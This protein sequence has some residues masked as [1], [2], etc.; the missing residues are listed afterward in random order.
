MPVTAWKRNG[1]PL[2][3]SQRV[4]RRRIPAGHPAPL[5]EERGPVSLAQGRVL[6]ADTDRHVRRQLL[7]LLDQQ[8]LQVDAV[9]TAEM[10]LKRVKARAYDAVFL[11]Q[12]ALRIGG[13]GLMRRIL[14]IRPHA[15]VVL[16]VACDSRESRLGAM[17]RG[18]FHYLV[19][20]VGPG[21]LEI[22]VRS[23]LERSRLLQQNAEL[24]QKTIQDDLTTAFNRRYLDA[25]L[26][27]ELERNR[28]Y[29]HTFSIVFFDLDHLKDVNNRHGHL[30]GSRVLREVAQLIQGELRKSDRIF[31]YGGD[32]FV[33]TLPETGT[34]GALCVAHRFRRVVRLHRFLVTEGLAVNLT[35]SFGV[36]TFPQDG[37]SQ[38][39]LLR[40]ADQAMYRVKTQTRDGVARRERK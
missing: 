22:V 26:D 13:L 18:A 2:R 7:D 30:V 19:K 33:V 35:A 4:E 24:Q 25:Y 31:R 29:G 6:I 23:C 9:T 36:A 11:D 39:A 27:D 32:E 21:T 28:R 15:S 17:K 40:A 8:G 12:E 16:M 3:P 5:D 14:R 37:A 34:E 1:R 10:A 20:P 38:K